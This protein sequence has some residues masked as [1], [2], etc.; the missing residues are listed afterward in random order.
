MSVL[1]CPECHSRDIFLVSR[2]YGLPTY[3]CKTCSYTGQLIIALDDNASLP[4]IRKPQKNRLQ[5]DP[6]PE[7]EGRRILWV[8]LIILLLIIA[9]LRQAHVSIPL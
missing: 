8:I 6:V 2:L 7:T 1:I 3:Q 9:F 5:N 4:K